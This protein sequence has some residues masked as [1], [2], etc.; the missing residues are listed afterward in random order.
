[1]SISE[2]RKLPATEKLKIIEALWGDLAADDGAV[3]SPSWHA[4]ELAQTEDAYQKGEVQAVDW[5]E[6]K[7][8][9]RKRAE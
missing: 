2:L 4:A 3:E 6:A 9:L 8:E 7:R 5:E 1:M